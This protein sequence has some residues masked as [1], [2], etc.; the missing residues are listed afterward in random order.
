MTAWG[1]VHFNDDRP[2]PACWPARVGE[3]RPDLRAAALPVD[4]SGLGNLEGAEVRFLGG[5]RTFRGRD[6][7]RQ[8]GSSTACTTASIRL[9]QLTP[10]A[11]MW[12]NCVF[13]G[14]GVGLLN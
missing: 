11:G 13:G 8:L 2:N 5:R 12:F 3:R 14:K 7:G 10:L 9:A 4:Q 6:D 1:T